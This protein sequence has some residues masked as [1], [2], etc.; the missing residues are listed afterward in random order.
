MIRCTNCKKEIVGVE[1]RKGRFKEIC[2]SKKDTDT[3][4]H[5]CNFCGARFE[6]FVFE[7]KDIFREKG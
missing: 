4:K 5:I 6:T 1:I 3:V 7:I 2:S